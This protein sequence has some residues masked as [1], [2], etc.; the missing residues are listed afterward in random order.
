[1]SA[2]AKASDKLKD[3]GISVVAA[4]SDTLENTRKIGS[5]WDLNF[6]VAYG[7]DPVEVSNQLGA[8][9]EPERKI[10]HTTNYVIRPDGKIAVA[11]YSTSA[12]GRLVWQDV[13]ALTQYM[14][15]MMAK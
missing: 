5:E 11:V 8:F 14:K 10:V 6:P 3:E 2:Y 7:L 13:T 1:M 12:I 15:K 4:S 9:Y